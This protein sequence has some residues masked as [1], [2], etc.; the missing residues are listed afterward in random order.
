MGAMA[1]ALVAQTAG[2]GDITTGLQALWQ[3]NEGSGTTVA[4]GSGNSNVLTLGGGSTTPTWVS[5]YTG[6]FALLFDGNNDVA[7]A[8][9][10]SSLSPTSAITISAWVKTSGQG[11]GN[12]ATGTLIR[13]ENAYTVFI[14]GTSGLLFGI[15]AGSNCIYGTATTTGVWHHV[16]ATYDKSLGSNQMALYYDGALVANQTNTN[17]IPSNAN[18]VAM[19]GGLLYSDEQLNGTQNATR[20]YNRALTAAQVLYLF[21]NKL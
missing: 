4:D 1:Q 10:S 11:S 14:D 15:F 8:T 3:M 2:G 7:T 17:S 16:C 18:D 13:K 19:G 9:S 6:S 20:I 21:N 5:G 12:A